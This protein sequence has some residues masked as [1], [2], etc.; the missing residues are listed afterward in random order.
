MINKNFTSLEAKNY[1]HQPYSTLLEDEDDI[2]FFFTLDNTVILGIIVVLGEVISKP[3]KLLMSSIS[4]DKVFLEL[5]QKKYERDPWTKTLTST[6]PSI[7][8][9]EK[10]IICGSWIIT[11]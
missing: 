5:L 2:R 10:L 1:A 8:N 7:S 11:S 3:K 4:A 9:L 6:M